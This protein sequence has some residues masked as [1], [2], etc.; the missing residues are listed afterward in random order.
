MGKTNEHSNNSINGVLRVS[1]IAV[2]VFAQLLLIAAFTIL[3][4]QH[5]VTAY[6]LLDIV[7]AI[8]V[9]VLVGTNK[10]SAYT[11]AWML[12]VL[13][14]P[15]FGYVL[16][17]LWGRSGIHTRK[18]KKIRRILSES[19]IW[20]TQDPRILEE[21]RQQYPL[22]K[23]LSLY[24]EKE[25]FP[26]YKNTACQYFPLGE[27]QFEEM[28]ADMEQAER[29]IFIEFFIFAQGKLWDRVHQVLA[30]K[31][32]QGVEIRILYDDLGSIF[33]LPSQFIKKM[34]AENIQVKRFNPVYRHLA[35]LYIN[36]RNHQ[37]IVV[38]D[39]NAGYTGGTNLADEYA[40]LYEKHGHWKDTAIRLT[41][42]AVWSLTVTFLQMWEAE[43]NDKEDYWK[44]APTQTA[45]GQGYYQP[46]SDGP[47]NNPHN[48][49]EAS[50][51]QMINS[52]QDYIWISTPYLVIDD[53]MIDSL[54]MAAVSGIDVRIVTPK[55][56][57][58]W[59]VHIVT[60]SNY[61]KLLQAG[62]KI[63][64]YTPGYIHAKTILSDD[65]NAVTGSINMDYRSF[66]LHFENG[67]WICGAPVLADIKSDME[68][69]FMVSEEI[70]Y[71]EWK[72]I[73]LPIKILQNFLRLFMPLL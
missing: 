70:S 44:Y 39:G 46:F 34:K 16:Y 20:L 57:D 55:I 62:V 50:Y 71:G 61:G 42:D 21:I 15:V 22:Q 25:G 56:W 35:R 58:R 53:L 43:S 23:K 31:A 29:F 45:V 73:P 49:A 12:I 59:Y 26:A 18:S 32:A 4:Q 19:S 37:K 48:P 54:C 72:K 51:Q 47:V 69:T 63:Y 36:F 40:N 3:L 41:G 24:L 28:I 6:V 17:L 5:A 60:R 11:T 68:A 66:H 65:V 27:L 9:L 7:A 33:T 30:R 13:L 52:A 1:I 67:V 8:W 10:N 2:A 38:I 64:E 14:L